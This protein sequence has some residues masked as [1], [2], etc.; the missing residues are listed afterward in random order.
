MCPLVVVVAVVVVVF[1]CPL[2]GD[3]ALCV[4]RDELQ[5]KKKNIYLQ[6]IKQASA[7]R[8]ISKT[9]TGEDPKLNAN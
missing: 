2:V 8:N 1:N 7:V 9:S 4:R 6:K 5:G 3:E